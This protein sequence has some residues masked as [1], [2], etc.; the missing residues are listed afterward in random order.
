MSAAVARS[1]PLAHAPLA[2]FRSAVPRLAAFLL[3]SILFTAKAFAAARSASYAAS[4]DLT[5]VA[6]WGGVGVACGVA[7]MCRGLVQKQPVQTA[8]AEQQQP[9][10]DLAP[11]TASEGASSP[12]PAADDTSLQDGLRQRMLQLAAETKD[13]VADLP[14]EK[15]GSGST[16][17]LER[18]KEEQPDA[19]PNA[20]TDAASDLP[21]GYPLRGGDDWGLEAKPSATE[22]EIKMLER[23]FGTRSD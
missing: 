17:L 1:K 22:D 21:L 15:N 4:G 14:D 20:V 7:Y 12:T 19:A 2:A 13:E 23:M 9:S 8:A 3:S 5:G 6:K 10:D 16:A 11:P 18:P